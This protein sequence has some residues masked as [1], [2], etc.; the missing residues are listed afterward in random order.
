MPEQMHVLLHSFDSD[1][2]VVLAIKEPL[3]HNHRGR[4]P[5]CT[6]QVGA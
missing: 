6:A 5:S 3:Q 4:S 2:A 1:F